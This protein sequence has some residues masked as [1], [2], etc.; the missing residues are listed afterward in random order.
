MRPI[1]FF[2][3]AV[4]LAAAEPQ[5][6][7]SGAARVS[8]VELYTS[9]GC[10]S[11]PPAEKWLG[12][13]R[14][15]PGLWKTFVP[16]AFH[17]NYWDRLGWPDKFASREGTQREYAY[18][19]AWGAGNVYTPCVVR[20]GAE[21]RARGEKIPAPA[22]APAGALTASYDGTVVRAEFT[23]AAPRA[24]ERFEIHAALLGSGIV[25][26]VSAGENS[27]ETL[28]HEFVSLALAQ[29][30]PGADIALAAPAPKVAGVTRRGL[31]VWVTRRGELAP[32]QATGGWLAP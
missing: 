8:L 29:G 3:T 24:G 26:K 6:F 1:L 16:V 32:L 7:S 5:Q 15:D 2:A 12:S 22:G 4:A 20:D 14:D 25:S 30:A 27:G 23:P 31:A 21:W 13:F 19:E 28:R 9:E 18:A 10:S 17:V 11:C